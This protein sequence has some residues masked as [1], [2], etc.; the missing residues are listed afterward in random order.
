MEVAAAVPA[1]VPAAAVC[2]FGI[3]PTL[4]RFV[5]VVFWRFFSLICFYLFFISQRILGLNFRVERFGGRVS[6]FSL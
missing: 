5:L 4:R 2:F 1:A 6:L 3:L